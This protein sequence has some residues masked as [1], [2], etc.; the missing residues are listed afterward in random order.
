ML[1]RGGF[2]GVSGNRN[3]TAKSRSLKTDA[4]VTL[5]K[6]EGLSRSTT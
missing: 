1:F 3:V 5:L 6:A 4:G 2:V